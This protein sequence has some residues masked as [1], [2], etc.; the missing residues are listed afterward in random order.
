MERK[1]LIKGLIALNTVL[2]CVFVWLFISDK[3]SQRQPV[4]QDEVEISDSLD[5]LE[6]Q[7]DSLESSDSSCVYEPGK[8]ARESVSGSLSG[9]IQSVTNNC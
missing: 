3:K 9:I 1:R 2:L 6:K 8:G 5:L 4:K 7:L